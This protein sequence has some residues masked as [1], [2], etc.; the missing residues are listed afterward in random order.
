MTENHR[1]DSWLSF[2]LAFVGGYCDAA[3]YVLAKT[4]TGHI[5]GTLVLAAISLAGRNWGTLLRH[6]LAIALFLIGVVL[7]LLS[8]RFAPRIP[9]RFLLPVVM[10]VEIV[11]IS[12]S[13]FALVSH[14]TPRFGLL[15]GCM[16]FAMG[17]QN[18][19]FTQ[20]G[21]ISVHTTYLTGTITSLL[22]T[23]TRKHSSETKT[24]DA[25]AS[26]QKVK[27]FAGVWLAFVAGAIVGPAMVFWLGARGVVGAAFVLIAIGVGPFQS[28]R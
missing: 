28:R 8:G 6:L 7:S 10:G 1:S 9:S 25:L 13:Y 22:K 24:G 11:L 19:A 12:I 18:G 23:E 27:L 20:A 14:L 2:G 4:F 16:S 3:G 21:G 26:D 15:V 17:L 5:T